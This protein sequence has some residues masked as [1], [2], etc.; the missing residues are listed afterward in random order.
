MTLQEKIDHDLKE[1]MKARAADTLSVLR[2]VKAA[3]KNASIEKGGM[4]AQ[5]DDAEST[6][7]IRKEIKKRQDSVEAFEKAARTEL[8]EK[9]K[10]EIVILNAYLPQALSPEAIANIVTLAIAEVGATSKAQMGAVIKLAAEKAAGRTDGR[11]LSA[12]VQRQLAS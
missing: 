6:A 9:E 5:L 11:T 4:S 1:A 12:E 10:A 8:A 7:I 2:M 3:L